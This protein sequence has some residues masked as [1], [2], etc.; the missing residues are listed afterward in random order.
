MG[1][2][3]NSELLRA[4]PSHSERLLELSELSER[5]LRATKAFRATPSYSEW[6]LELSKLSERLFGAT[7]A[8]KARKKL[9]RLPSYSELGAP[10]NSELLKATQEHSE[11]LRALSE[12][13]SSLPSPEL[14]ALPSSLFTACGQQSPLCAV[15]GELG[16]PF[17]ER[18]T[19]PQPPVF[20]SLILQ[21]N[22]PHDHLEAEEQ[23]FIR[24]FQPK[25]NGY[26]AVGERNPA[27][28][29]WAECSAPFH[30]EGVFVHRSTFLPG[31][32]T[33][34]P[35]GCRTIDDQRI[36]YVP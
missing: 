18:E 33:W 10:K 26:L 23:T 20:L 8:L 16:P 19:T 13:L 17:L 1:A 28:H 14:Q 27:E 25:L 7:R 36:R 35:S 4:T 24:H 31:F 11:L 29:E 3:K 2:L 21:Y 12:L 30:S 32:G 6:L 9:R 15:C 34:C 22:V 5:L